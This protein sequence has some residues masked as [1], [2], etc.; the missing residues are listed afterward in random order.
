[1]APL[2]SLPSSLHA[3]IQR[4]V[5]SELDSVTGRSR[6]LDFSDRASTPLTEAVLLEIQRMGNVAPV[7]VMHSTARDATLDGHFIPKDTQVG[8]WEI[9]QDPKRA[10][11]KDVPRLSSCSFICLYLV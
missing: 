9:G 7:G 1:M 2:L 5:Q 3:D 10:L 4:Q 11:F 6:F 8:R